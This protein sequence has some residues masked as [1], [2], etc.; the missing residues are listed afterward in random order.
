[1]FVDLAEACD[2]VLVFAAAD[3][4]PGHEVRDGDVGLVGPGANEIDKLVARIVGDPL[5]D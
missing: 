4:D 2:P 5:P 3:A 1:V